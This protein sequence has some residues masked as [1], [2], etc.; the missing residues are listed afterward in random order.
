MKIN[1]EEI[2]PGGLRLVIHEEV[3]D[4]PQYAALED[5]EEIN[6]TAP[7]HV[8]L[9]LM[10]IREIVEMTGRLKSRIATTCSRCLADLAVDLE[11]RFQLVYTRRP[12]T[13]ARP[14][15]QKEIELTTEDVGLMLFDGEVIDIGPGIFEEALAALPLKPL[16]R[17]DCRGLCPRCGADL[18]RENC[19]CRGKDVDP[20]L[21]KLLQLKK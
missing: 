11:N 19:R 1:V 12:G 5:S 16:C 15:M 17:D 18:N 21:A 6:Y 7:L 2:P 14:S 10:R 9:I 8:E 13:K 4:N 3:K 20:R